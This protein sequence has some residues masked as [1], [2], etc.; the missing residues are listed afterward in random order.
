MGVGNFFPAL[1]I[2]AYNFI[3]LYSGCIVSTMYSFTSNSDAKMAQSMSHDGSFP[4]SIIFSLKNKVGAL[5]SVLAAFT[6]I[7]EQKFCYYYKS[8]NYVH[9]IMV[10]S[11][12]RSSTH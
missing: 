7:S 9:L 11:W 12:C 5:K 4:V 6:V 1:L 2:F 8:Y 10:G 3:G